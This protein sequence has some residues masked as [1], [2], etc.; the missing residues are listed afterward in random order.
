MVGKS[1]FLRRH[2]RIITIVLAVVLVP[3]VACGCCTGYALLALSWPNIRANIVTQGVLPRV[4]E[5]ARQIKAITPTDNVLIEEEPPQAGIKEY[6]AYELGDLW[7][8]Q[9]VTTSTHQV[10]DT[11]L[12]RDAFINVYREQFTQWGW[13][14]LRLGDYSDTLSAVFRSPD[15]I[16]FLLHVMAPETDKNLVVGLCPSPD[17]A[18]APGM[19]RF[20]VFVDFDESPYSPDCGGSHLCIVARNYCR[21]H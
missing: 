12:D 13:D 4:E 17:L 16:N 10:Y 11:A 8:K 5:I 6:R 3:V 18:T 1:A 19:T 2:K 20:V 21:A 15:D 14:T 7:A 9:Y